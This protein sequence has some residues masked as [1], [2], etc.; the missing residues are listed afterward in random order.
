MLFLPGIDS[1]SYWTLLGRGMA[2]PEVICPDPSCQGVLGAR[3]WYWRYLGGEHVPL[4][5]LH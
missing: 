1:K 2:I 5:R 4:R 3:G